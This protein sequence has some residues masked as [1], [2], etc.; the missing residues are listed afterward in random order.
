MQQVITVWEVLLCLVPQGLMEL[1]RVCRSYETA[2]SVLP[3]GY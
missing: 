3:V 1:Q 2:Q